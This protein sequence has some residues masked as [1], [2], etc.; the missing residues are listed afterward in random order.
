MSAQT[1]LWSPLRICPLPSWYQRISLPFMDSP[2]TCRRRCLLSKG[3]GLMC[4]SCPQAKNVQAGKERMH[5]QEAEISALRRQLESMQVAASRAR[6]GG[7]GRRQYDGSVPAEY[8][9]PI[10]QASLLR[11]HMYQQQ[12]RTSRNV[13]GFTAL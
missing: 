11:W 13:K 5:A 7:G 4:Q 12:R 1:Q 6:A 10:T 8:L 2:L 3:S 9:C